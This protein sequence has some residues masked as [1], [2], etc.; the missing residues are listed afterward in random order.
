MKRSRRAV[1]A[2]TAV[3][4]TLA[5]A[6]GT[7]ATAEPK[8]PDYRPGAPATQKKVPTTAVPPAAPPA[9]PEIRQA[10]TKPAPQWPAASSALVNLAATSKQAVTSPVRVSRTGA[11]TGQVRV[12]VLDRSTTDRAGVRGLLIRLGRATPAPAADSVNVTVDYRSFR[13]AYGG[14]WAT[15]L[16]LTT[17]PECALTTPDKIGCAGSA[18]PSRNDAKAGSV[19]A[20][21][22]L[23]T[24]TLIAVTAG[25]SGPAGAFTATSL[26][27]SSTWSAGGNSGTFGWSYPMRVP[28]AANGPAPAAG[29]SYSSQSVDGRHAASN[30]QPGWAGEGFE[31]T[32]GGFIERR[33][34]SCLQDMDANAAGDK[35]N[36]TEK[37][38]DL[39]WATDNAMLSLGNHS[40]ELLYNAT[41]KRWHLRNDD[42]SRIERK[43]GAVNG[44][45]DGEWWVVTTTDGTQYWFGAHRLPGWAANDPV[46]NSTWTVPVFGNHS[47]EPC[48]ES[49]YA[50]SDCTQAWRWNLD[51]V[52]D[53]HG[54]SASY[55][56]QKETNR[57]ARNKKATD[58]ALYDRGGYLDHADYGTRRDDGTE[59]VLNTQAPARIDF[60]VAD[61]CLSDCGTHNEARWPDTPWDQDCQADKDDCRNVSPTFWSTKRLASVTTQLRD[62]TGWDDVERWTLT[63]TFPDPGDTTRA[64]LWLSKLSHAGLVGGIE[65]VPDTEFTGVQLANRVDTIDFAAAMNWWRISQIRTET[66]GT[67]S[68]VYSDPDCVAKTRVP[69]DP[70]NNTLRCYPVR[71]TPEGYQNPVTDYFHRYL[72]KT[73]Y[74]A[75]NTG[76]VTPKGSPRKVTTY[77]YHGDPA[78]HYADD[79]GL[80]E[81]KDKTW[82]VWRGYSKVG[83][84]TG[85]AGEQQYT[86]STYFR[87]MHGDK[88]SSGTRTVTMPGTGVPTVNDEDSYAGMV[89][90]STVHNGPGSAI[91]SRS[92]SEPWRSGI[93]ASRTINGDT[94]EARF[95]GVTATHH[96]TVRDGGRPDQVRTIRKTFDKYGM[97]IAED[98]SGDTAVTGDESCTKTALEPRNT[99]IWLLTPEHREQT[100]AT[101]CAAAADLANLTESHVISDTRSFYDDHDHGAPPSKGLLTRSEAASAWNTGNP[102]FQQVSRASYDTHGRITASWDG[103]DHVTATA[104]TPTTG[105]LATHTKATNALGHET[106]TTLH[107]AWG[108]P[109]RIVDANDKVTTATYDP[110]GRATAVW[111]PGRVQGVDTPNE[112]FAYRIRN[113][114]TSWVSS[115]T[116]NP[117][118]NYVTTYTL[119]DGLLRT[120]QTQVPSASGGRL[121]TDVFYDTSGRKVREHGAYY[122]S[123]TP[124]GDLNTATDRQ[125]VPKQTRTVYDGAGRVTAEIFQP[126]TKER[127]QT[128]MRYGGDHID[129]TPP[130]GGTATATYT[131][132]LGRTVATRQYHGPTPTGDYDATT[133][134][135]NAKRQLQKVTD[136]AGNTWSYTYDLRGRQLTFTDPDKGKT[137]NEYDNAGRMTSATDARGIKLIYQYDELDRRTALLQSGVGARAR[138][139]YDTVATGQLTQSVRL[140]GTASYIKRI[141]SYD[142]RYKPTSETV[143]VPAAEAGLAG[144]YTFANSYALD[145]SLAATT[146]PESADLPLETTQYR[147]NENTGL[148][149]QL[150]S[151]YGTTSTSYVSRTDY[152]AQNSINQYVLYTGHYSETGSRVYRVIDRELET[153]RVIGIRTD[154]ESV[155]PHTVAN[156]RYTFD[157]AGNITQAQDAA[158]GDAQCFRYDGLRRLSEAWT[159]A[160]APCSTNPAT[161]LLGGPAPYWQSW[162]YNAVGNRL[163]QVDHAVGSV[164][165]DRTTRYDYPAAG[166]TQPHALASTTVTNGSTTTTS[167]Y[168]Y[169]A[170]GGM[171]SR[172]VAGG[173]QT[174]AYDPEARLGTS[175]DSGGSTTYIYDADGNRLI[176]RDPAGSTLYLAGEDRRWTKATGK[177]AT[178]RYYSYAGS[179]IASR[180]AAGLTWLAPDHQGTGTVA[181]NERTQAAV[182]R[183]QKP[184]GESRGATV[185]W[186]N[187]KGFVGGNVD[188]TGLTQLGARMYD[189]AI[190]RFTSVDP[191]QDLNDPQQW[192]GYSYANNSPVTGSDP[193]GL[194][195]LFA[196]GDPLEDRRI[197]Q[198][199][200]LETR[201]DSRG[202]WVITSAGKGSAPKGSWM[203]HYWNTVRKTPKSG[204]YSHI[205]GHGVTD[206]TLFG[207][208]AV[209]DNDGNLVAQDDNFRSGGGLLPDERIQGDQHI[210]PR[211]VKWYESAGKLKP[212]Y[213]LVITVNKEGAPSCNSCRPF[214]ADTAAKK[215]I[216]VLYMEPG[217]APVPFGETN[218]SAQL[219]GNIV[220]PRAPIKTKPQQL[221]PAEPHAGKTPVRPRGGTGNMGRGMSGTAGTLGAF[222]MA[223]DLYFLVR[224]GPCALAPVPIPECQPQSPLV[225]D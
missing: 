179:S 171:Q 108:L 109:T 223:A 120:R 26:Q 198:E 37:T 51:Y 32:T 25:P 106:T 75:D 16:R 93:T 195:P 53:L 208:A 64:G 60:A 105:G 66:G 39:C 9:Q 79:D 19:S 41:E 21:V 34:E 111:K 194:R 73:V 210:E 101:T 104:Y 10:A 224:Y 196:G 190:G 38:G 215:G 160:T 206:K 65:T 197:L 5:L 81:K 45:D 8:E 134:T 154:R 116:L 221:S 203:E 47:R 80:V 138:W 112:K 68:V 178:T 13:T 193:D 2:L 202:K 143:T 12:D 188:P 218:S 151:T 167:S 177:V 211:V 125:D 97:V 204:K 169:D 156:T 199:E 70:A 86:E 78:W 117:A 82:S 96:R 44:D 95:S 122:A 61:R 136:T 189:P 148:V 85:D 52:V 46:T 158:A 107:P 98:D 168:S 153:G 176:S 181:I 170:T 146:Y 110:L 175:T 62:G 1:A 102:T 29:L 113:D 212:G 187:G 219:K 103:L 191:V 20:T 207:A 28:P 49:A 118:G 48:N 172:P 33:Y 213:T 27:P 137:T 59:T 205:Y 149:N 225:L 200:G 11:V 90:E 63:H 55:W 161:S 216:R 87:G 186:P 133:Y 135:F 150:M 147:Y 144:T 155:S 89:R 91:I 58:L 201:Q 152:D 50:D 217:K 142:D 56:Y 18:L 22:P 159:P 3:I 141:N 6:V 140:V 54:N 185:T 24:G 67:I 14:D 164:T 4:T 209:Y 42:G 166:G 115:S 132:A 174:L 127:W 157:A 76:G 126:Y 114:E 131:D 130:T 72:V 57:Y 214:L 165:T 129:V 184:F 94:V 119:Y 74:E 17:L 124:S 88:A 220:S 192:N 139:T 123:G 173:A 100:F 43:T 7:P 35:P 121:L 23:A 36:N 222:G 71:W 163:T 83:V 180:N 92:V 128:A 77:S 99:T 40:G 183:R 145:G 31:T 15:R 162:T 30:N 182:V 84:T 69:T